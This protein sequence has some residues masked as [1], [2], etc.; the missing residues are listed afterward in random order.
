MWHGRRLE[1]EHLTLTS[2]PAAAGAHLVPHPEMWED[3]DVPLHRQPSAGRCVLD[4]EPA[5]G[6]I[7]DAAETSAILVEGPAI[8]PLD[9]AV[10][11]QHVGPV[12]S[13]RWW[14]DGT[15]DLVELEPFASGQSDL[16]LG[17]RIWMPTVGCSTQISASRG[18]IARQLVSTTSAPSAIARRRDATSP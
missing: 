9:R 12:R 7:C 5:V 17:R 13:G 4:L 16:D 6:E 8:D 18:L 11:E 14:P 1:A 2:P 3:R 10:Q 15:I